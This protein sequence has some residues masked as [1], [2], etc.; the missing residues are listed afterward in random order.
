MI[1]TKD[2]IERAEEALEKWRSDAG[3][4]GPGLALVVPELIAALREAEAEKARLTLYGIMDITSAEADRDLLAAENAELKD[5]VSDLSM[6]LRRLLACEKSVSGPSV[7]AQAADYLKR[8]GLEGSP[9]R[10]TK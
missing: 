1:D 3:D 7:A 10:E 9:M 5:E 2:L 4:E 6:L 8:K